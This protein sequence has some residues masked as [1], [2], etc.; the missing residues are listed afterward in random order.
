L[1]TWFSFDKPPRKTY[2]TTT[3]SS[4]NSSTSARGRLT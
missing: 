2:F 3:N 1:S 4:D